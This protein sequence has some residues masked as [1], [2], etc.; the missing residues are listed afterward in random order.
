MLEQSNPDDCTESF[1]LTVDNIES[2]LYIR[3][4]QT[5]RYSICPG[6]EITL[7]LNITDLEG[8]SVKWFKDDTEIESN[9]SF[10]QINAYGS[11]YAVIQKN[12]CVYTTG[13][14]KLFAKKGNANVIWPKYYDLDLDKITI[15]DV[16]GN[17]TL[18][19]IENKHLSSSYGHQW[20]LN[21][22]LI[23]FA[24]NI[25][26]ETSQ[27]GTY[28]LTS[29]YGDCIIYSNK[30]QVEKGK[31]PTS[32][33]SFAYDSHLQ[34]V[35]K[36][37]LCEFK[38]D[39]D[40]ILLF[41]GFHQA[42]IL[43]DGKSLSF[44]QRYQ[45]SSFSKLKNFGEYTYFYQ[46][47]T[48]DI[49]DTLSIVKSDVED[50]WFNEYT[51]LADP[52]Y[53]K[54]NLN[55]FYDLKNYEDFKWYRNEQLF[56]TNDNFIWLYEPGTY[57]LEASD[58]NSTCTVKSFTYTN[59]VFT[60]PRIIGP[61]EVS[62]CEGETY[63]L[64][65]T[66][67]DFELTW[68]K[69]GQKW[70]SEFKQVISEE[71][72]YWYSIKNPYTDIYY[73]SDTLHLT[74]N[75]RKIVSIE[76]S[77][78]NENNTFQLTATAD[79][80]DKS[81][82]IWYK[83][84]QEIY[85]NDNHLLVTQPGLYS[86]YNNAEQCAS[87]PAYVTVGL[88]VREMSSCITNAL[89]YHSSSSYLSLNIFDKFNW[90]D[91]QSAIISSTENL[92]YTPERAGIFSY[93]LRSYSDKSSCEF[94][95][96]VRVF[97]KDTIQVDYPQEFN[98]REGDV[99]LNF[100]EL[101]PLTTSSENF[102]NY[103]FYVQNSNQPISL[104]GKELNKVDTGSYSI[105]FSSQYGCS[106]TK[107]FKINLADKKD[108]GIEIKDYNRDFLCDDIP[109][110][111]NLLRSA[112]LETKKVIAQISML[113]WRMQYLKTIYAESVDDQLVF[114]NIDKGLSYF[115]LK[116][117]LEDNPEEYVIKKIT[118]NTS[119]SFITLQNL[120]IDYDCKDIKLIIPIS[121]AK[122]ITWYK[123]DILLNNTAAELLVNEDGQYKATYRNSFDSDNSCL[124]TAQMQLRLPITIKPTIEAARDLNCNGSN[125]T[126]VAKSQFENQDTFTWRKNGEIINENSD[127]LFIAKVN[128]GDQYTVSYK[129]LSCSLPSDSYDFNKTQK[130][131]FFNIN[132]QTENTTYTYNYK[133]CDDKPITLSYQAGLEPDSLF[134]F[135]DKQLIKDQTKSIL[136]KQSGIYQSIA[137]L[138]GCKLE[139]N[140]FN[141]SISDTLRIA[142]ETQKEINL[143]S[144][145]EHA[146][147]FE[148]LTNTITSEEI[149]THKVQWFRNN[150]PIN[151]YYRAASN[152]VVIDDEEEYSAK[153]YIITESGKICNVKV[154][155]FQL[156]FTNSIKTKGVANITTCAPT[157]RIPTNLMSSS[158]RTL[159]S[160]LY[161]NSVKVSD[162]AS[163]AVIDQNGVYTVKNFTKEGCII[164]SKD[165]EVNFETFRT[166][167]TLKDDPIICNNHETTLFSHVSEYQQDDKIQWYRDGE[168]IPNA[169]NF[170]LTTNLPG[171]YQVKHTL[172]SCSDTS[173]PVNLISVNI[174]EELKN[175]DNTYLCNDQNITLNYDSTFQATW[176]K[177]GAEIDL[178]SK[179]KIVINDEGKY[180]TRLSKN[181][182][183]I[184]IPIF[185]VQKVAI[186]P[187]ISLSGTQFICPTKS[188]ILEGTYQDDI[189]VTLLKNGKPSTSEKTADTRFKLSDIAS[190][191][192]VYSKGNC[193]VLS[194]SLSL[195]ASIDGSFKQLDS[196]FC[197][198]NLA[199]IQ[200]AD[201]S[202]ASILWYRNDTLIDNTEKT[203]YT[204]QEGLYYASIIGE[205]CQINTDTIA[206]SQIK[207]PTVVISG[208]SQ[209]AFDDSALI[210][211]NV[212]PKIATSI[213]LSDGSIFEYTPGKDSLYLT[214]NQSV[215]YE[216]Q[217]VNNTCGEG[218]FSGNA[219]IEILVLA[220]EIASE[221][222]HVTVYPNPS[223]SKVVIDH[224]DVKE[225]NLTT[226]NGKVICVD[227]LVENNS[228]FIDI[229]SLPSGKYILQ[230]SLKNN[231][232]SKQVIKL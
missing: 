175:L 39:R 131:Y 84:G 54:I 57:R 198:N 5:Y 9:T 147:T 170:N 119:F 142:Y 169:N 189:E 187:D 33:L 27:E 110:N 79:T 193:E 181:S 23:P 105:K 167:L 46:Q 81:H 75:K 10:I 182:C 25:E 121:G 53:K 222:I 188:I 101:K 71:G 87:K 162:D 146:V 201:N 62:I 22:E 149:N 227:T 1:V 140:E 70:E 197:E 21:D 124:N 159:S 26:Y 157:V 173:E 88:P 150:Q 16:G 80:Q 211:F 209:I 106:T 210:Y 6:S 185:N 65:I 178:A 180:F 82:W 8:Y 156:K 61:K 138:N 199:E 183:I 171:S 127:R 133:G 11:Y 90:L 59:S 99:F 38:E 43:Q 48:C 52:P 143:C 69:N 208:S 200:L 113:N 161:R 58:K 66:S 78:G 122:D 32:G 115:I 12:T 218:D 55:G 24:T 174:P 56:N 92:N 216:I 207:T 19:S 72:Y 202:N 7:S 14:L 204:D 195:I 98:F 120:A 96:K 68:Y 128:F 160:E 17:V 36:L 223:S 154:E 163:T 184:T 186:K 85:Q 230:F 73:Y 137:Y 176:Y 40:F 158:N 221:N 104:I 13:E 44:T 50:A 164:E 190:Y 28:S 141:L 177:N 76:E 203:L 112:G 91:E 15:C 117:W 228:T 226:M 214:P 212:T 45:T 152:S 4:G 231:L 215:N 2:P 166:W 135:K 49:R 225:V 114:S 229:S 220:N 123:N 125:L 102:E 20:Y 34:G 51:I 63:N 111:I 148:H 165:I 139:S 132:Y 144:T 94:I 18:T 219:T 130:S 168:L 116:I 95:Q 205:D 67:D 41:P 206:L 42:Q 64:A 191:Q 100:P 31:K 97:I 217:H 74:V 35:K 232:I 83:D 77:C 47:G 109:L 126:L 153:G 93:T 118:A 3:S 213:T 29:T 136:A 194:E 129:N 192:L 179:G 89:S 37:H 151:K 196:S 108:I 224:T 107:N 60:E 134:W 103:N 172:A 86:V 155:P 30:I 145:Y